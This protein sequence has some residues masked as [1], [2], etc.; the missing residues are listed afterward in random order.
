VQQPT[1]KRYKRKIAIAR[2]S[3]ESNY[4]RA[5]MTDSDYDQIGKQTSDMLISKLVKSQRFLVFERTDLKKLLKEQAISGEASLV[6]VDAVIIGSVSEFGRSVTGKSAWLSG[7]KV[8]TAKAKVDARIV[9]VKTGQ[10]FF[11][12]TGSG[13]ATTESSEVAGYGSH[14]EYDATLNDR[15]ISAAISDLIDKLVS[16][17]DERPWKSDILNVQG[18][19]V[20]ISGGKLQGLK[21]GDDLQV[22]E[23]G[24]TLKSAQTGFV[25]NLPPKKIATVRVAS[26]FG[27]NENNEGSVCEFVSGA[28]TPGGP[29]QIYVEEV[30]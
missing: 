26:F 25:I 9:D 16:S 29:N 17:L 10:A 7:T 6:G 8:Q 18:T 13:E 24:Q 14:A 30:R 2:F 28:I 21:V 22:M 15:A 11:S 3:N 20:F 19:N 23:K 1:A 5:L 27:D 12:V 4:G